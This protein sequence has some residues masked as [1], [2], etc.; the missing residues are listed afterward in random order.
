MTQVQKCQF[1]HVSM[2]RNVFFSFFKFK[3]RD[4]FPAFYDND[5]VLSPCPGVQFAHQDISEDKRGGP[6]PH[7]EI[8]WTKGPL[9]QPQPYLKIYLCLVALT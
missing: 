3:C 5:I 6:Q 9:P 7:F 4:N 8:L 1:H 2:L